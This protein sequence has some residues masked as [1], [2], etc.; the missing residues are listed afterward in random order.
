MSERD[1]KG[2]RRGYIKEGGKK[3]VTDEL[4]E[5][6]TSK[7]KLCRHWQVNW[8]DNWDQELNADKYRD[9]QKDREKDS[10][11]KIQKHNRHGQQ[12]LKGTRWL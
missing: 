10:Y 9:W 7:I 3:V 5:E 8:R 11:K 2:K 4:T 6:Q 12:N 1:S